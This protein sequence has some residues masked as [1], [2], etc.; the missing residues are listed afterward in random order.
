MTL[1][2]L[3]IALALVSLGE[4]SWAQITLD[5]GTQTVNSVIPDNDLGGIAETVSLGSSIV[6]ISD[7]QLTLDIAGNSS[8]QP[9]NGD[10]YAYLVHGS[11]FAVLL[12]RVGV[13][14]ASNP[15]D[16]G[17]G[18]TG[19]DVTFSSAGSDIHNYQSGAYT[20]N[21]DGQLTGT[22][23]VDGRSSNPASVN[24]SDPRTALL[25]SFDGTGSAGDWTL[26]IADVS[27]G[28]IGNLVSWDLQVEGQGVTNS[29]PDNF[30]T[31][32][33]LALGVSALALVRRQKSVCQAIRA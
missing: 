27:P 4:R 11:G 2:P 30:S 31:M 17:Y 20:L 12:N 18:D 8:Y 13:T 32:W 19:F 25:S 16:F 26:F 29:A 22:W 28:G 14:S 24:S 21:S 33:L 15:N 10:Y 6:S 23:G 1:K 5:S 3:F 9:W 7:V